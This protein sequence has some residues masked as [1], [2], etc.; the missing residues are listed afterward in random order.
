MAKVFNGARPL[1]GF[2]RAEIRLHNI[3]SV[4]REVILMDLSLGQMVGSC[5]ERADSCTKNSSTP[6]RAKCSMVGNIRES[7]EKQLSSMNDELPFTSKFVIEGKLLDRC[8]S[9]SISGRSWATSSC[10]DRVRRLGADMDKSG[11]KRGH[12]RSD[13][14]R[15]VSDGRMTMSSSDGYTGQAST[16]RLR[17][18]SSLRLGM[19][20]SKLWKA[21][22]DIEEFEDRLRRVTWS[23][24]GVKWVAE[25]PMS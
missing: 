13:S 6:A 12:R 2:V 14:M 5:R 7:C 17:S 24:G 8:D 1:V 15:V 25:I 22:N 19:L 21:E 3:S 9:I 23:S 4:L 10:K 18:V 11:T 16:T 20:L